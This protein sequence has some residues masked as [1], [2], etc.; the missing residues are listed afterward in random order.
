MQLIRPGVEHAGPDQAEADRPGRGDGEV[1]R[2]AGQ[3]DRG[4]G[5]DRRLRR[6]R[7]RRAGHRPQGRRA[8][9]RRIRRP[10]GGAGRRAGDEAVQAARHADR[11]RREG[12]HLA[13]AGDAARRCA[14][15]AA[16]G[17]AALREPDAGAARRLAAPQGFRSIV[18]RLGLEDRSAPR[19]RRRGCRRRRRSRCCDPIRAR[20]RAPAPRRSGRTRSS[21]PREPCAPGSPR[22]RA[23]AASRWIPRP[24]GWTRCARGWSASSLATAPGRACYVPLRHE[25]LAGA[26]AA[27]RMR[28]TILGA[29]AD[30]SGGAEDLPKRQVRH[31]GAGARRLPAAGAGR[32]HH[33]DLLRPGSRRC[34]ATGWTNCRG[35]ISATRRSRYD[36]VTGT[37]RNRISFAQVPIDRA[38]AYAA[39]DA[40]VALRLWQTPAAAPARERRRWR[41]TSRSSAG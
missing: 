26:A 18:A 12:A 30:R 41:C 19:R 5:A 13:R 1:R 8:A 32:R 34:T 16:A 25:V 29:A 21:P 27:R 24:T 31:D 28:S 38:T 40:D 2:H 9:D 3:A 33:A 35:C 20:R 37:G 7:A 14:A 36:E 4:A 6:Q 22:R 15:A 17:R 39:E 11:A 23:A 10:R